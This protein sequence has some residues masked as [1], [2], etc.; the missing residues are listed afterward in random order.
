MEQQRR[1][2]ARNARRVKPGGRLIYSTCSLCRQANE[3]IVHAF[4][5]EDLED[6]LTFRLE[7]LHYLYPQLYDGDGFGVARLVRI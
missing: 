3:D 5:N 2:L 7:S 4:L 6:G 1:I